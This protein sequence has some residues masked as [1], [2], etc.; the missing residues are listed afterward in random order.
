MSNELTRRSAMRVFAGEGAMSAIALYGLDASALHGQEP[1]GKKFIINIGALDCTRRVQL[2][3][4]D[5]SSE[6]WYLAPE[7]VCSERGMLIIDNFDVQWSGPDSEGALEHTWATSQAYLDVM[8]SRYKFVD[9][10][11][12]IRYR[13]RLTP[14]ANGV[15]IDF[16]IRNT[17]KTVLENVTADFCL[18]NHG[19]PVYP[20]LNRKVFT[21]NLE[22]RWGGRSFLDTDSN[23]TWVY[24]GGKLVQAGSMRAQQPW[25]W[26]VKG[27]VVPR[28]LLA[29]YGAETAI[30]DRV[31][32]SVICRSSVSRDWSV[33]YGWRR[34]FL[35]WQNPSLQCIH[36][37]PEFGNIAPGEEASNRGAIRL[38]NA[39]PEE[40]CKFFSGELSARGRIRRE[41]S[42]A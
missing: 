42:A 37:D 3:S 31:D 1:G 7:N 26:M 9:E 5:L 8:R 33:V 10:Q 41:A 14:R 36:V 30:E 18:I 24:A 22:D 29:F 21:R 17:G 27:A 38:F 28:P 12:S 20:F 32:K 13:V 34:A 40:A 25:K 23:R 19:Y 16:R 15:D 11:G 2:I 4:P 35:V 6:W 39:P